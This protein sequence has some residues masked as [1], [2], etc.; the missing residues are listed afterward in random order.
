MNRAREALRLKIYSEALAA[1]QESLERV[2]ALTAD[3]DAARDESDSL[4]QLLDSLSRSKVPVQPFR[5]A[6]EMA[7]LHLQQMDVDAAR[8]FLQ[9][10][11]REIGVQAYDFFSQSL[12]RVETLG[13]MA[14]EAGFLSEREEKS[15]AEARHLLEEGAL[16]QVGEKLAGFDVM[17]RTNAAPVRRS[18][19]GGAREGLC[20]DPK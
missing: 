20:R 9:Q 10:T 14:H 7:Q 3:L 1:A 13:R 17:L 19:R 6:L 11:I 18:A 4:S 15:L 2:A 5:H 8:N 12:Q 16:V